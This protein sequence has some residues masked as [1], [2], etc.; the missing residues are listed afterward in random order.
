MPV[1]LSKWRQCPTQLSN[2][3]PNGKG[4]CLRRNKESTLQ[5]ADGKL[6]TTSL[7]ALI[8]HVTFLE[9]VIR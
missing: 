5:R 4:S 1:A 7:S 3:Q 2:A 6:S 8:D 9:V